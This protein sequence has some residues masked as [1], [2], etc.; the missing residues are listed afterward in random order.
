MKKMVKGIVSGL[1]LFGAF[2]VADYVEVKTPEGTYGYT[3]SAAF[4]PYVCYERR[5][6]LFRNGYQYLRYEGCVRSQ[7]SCRSIGM[8]HFGRYPNNSASYRALQRCINSTP[9]F[10]D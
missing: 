7:Q 6:R 5:V 10:V 1:L 4:L 8:V 2:G 3:R 9:R